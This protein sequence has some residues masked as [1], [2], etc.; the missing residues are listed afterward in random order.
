MK[1]KILQILNRHLI[2]GGMELY[3]FNLA[4]YLKA[5]GHDVMVAARPDTD[6]TNAVLKEGI[7]IIPITRGGAVQPYNV[8]QIA[9][10]LVRHKFDIMHSH[11]GNDYWPPLLAKWLT[12]SR[13][14]RVF[15]TRHLLSPPRGFSTRF[16]FQNVDT[17]CVSKNVLGVMKKFSA[18]GSR[19]HLVYPGIKTALFNSAPV[20]PYYREKYSIGKDEFVIG[21]MHKW[22]SKNIKILAALLNAFSDI[23]IILA[24]ALKD[25]EIDELKKMGSADRVFLTGPIRNMPEFYKSCNLFVFPSF[26]EAFGMVVCEALASGLPVLTADTGGASEIFTES[27]ECGFAMNA[28]SPDEFVKAAAFLKNNPEKLSLFSANAVK[29]GMK[30]DISSM[31]DGVEKL[32]FKSLGLIK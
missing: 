20:T 3:T 23:K 31:V 25:F 5:R 18:E 8:F 13:N 4:K 17:I 7:G 32:Y 22:F 9:K 19:L 29:T 14:S 21:T 30:Y 1:L 11:T 12:A 15:V 28:D 24:G 16:Y 26:D 27:D 10:G 6:F 2:T